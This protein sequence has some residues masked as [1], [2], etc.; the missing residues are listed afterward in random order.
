M[1]RMASPTFNGHRSSRSS[2]G[3]VELGLVLRVECRETPL[4]H[5]HIRRGGGR[6]RLCGAVRRN[7]QLRGLPWGAWWSLCTRCYKWT[8]AECRLT[9]AL[10]PI[11]TSHCR[12]ERPLLCLGDHGKSISGWQIILRGCYLLSHLVTPCRFCAKI[13]I[14]S[15]RRLE[16]WRAFKYRCWWQMSVWCTKGCLRQAF[17]KM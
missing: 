15:R 8:D 16:V 17:G 6:G 3:K 12:F 5:C 2:G 10:I 1:V 13:A 14:E 11:K 7:M 4:G 9:A